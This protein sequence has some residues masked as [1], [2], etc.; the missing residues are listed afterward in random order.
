MNNISIIGGGITGLT[1]A[2]A[3]KKLGLDG[4]VFER[5]PALNE[6]GAG[7]WMQ[8]NAMKVLDWLGLGDKIRGA[9]LSIEG[10]QVTDRRLIPM[11][12]FKPASITGDEGR[13]TISIHRARLQKILF[14]ALPAN[15]VQLGKA[16]HRH[17]TENGKVSVIF[18]DASTAVCDLLLGADGIHSMVRKQLF[19]FS[20]IRYSGQTCWR[21]IA[22]MDNLP[23]PFKATGIEAWG[24]QIRFGFANI[25]QNEVY[26]YAVAKAP[27]NQKEESGAIKQKLIDNFKHFNSLVAEI[28]NQTP[29]KKIIRNDISDLKRLKT[30]RQGRICLLGDAAHATTPNL[31]QGGGQGVE[32]AYYIGNILAQIPDYT[33]AFKQFEKERRKKVDYVVNTSWQ[34]GKM[35]HLKIGPSLM[36]WLFKF[37]PEKIA[38]RQFAKLH[39]VKESFEY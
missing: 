7:I 24:D 1:T 20:S 26:W 28:I 38:A 12:K 25:S 16:Y 14:D 23:D 36:K 8:P 34:L 2:L 3:L 11:R 5:A 10:V 39:A 21:G 37:T 32:D 22:S 31:G 4:Q 15:S 30:W 9:G 27:Q 6:I 35:A 29:S 13:K 33:Q 19:P 17:H 18:E